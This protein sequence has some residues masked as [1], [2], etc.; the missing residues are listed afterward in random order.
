MSLTIACVARSN[1]T[2]DHESL[3]N[4]YRNM[5]P[6]EAMLD[7][8]AGGPIA[9]E[10]LFL[11]CRHYLCMFVFDMLNPLL[12]STAALQLAWAAVCISTATN[13]AIACAPL[14]G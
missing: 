9:G 8:S 10:G 11:Q 7:R 3:I 12:D 5:A 1:C 6:L 14:T 2:G 4:H 13:T